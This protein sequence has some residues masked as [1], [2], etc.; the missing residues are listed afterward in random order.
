MSVSCEE[1]PASHFVSG[2]KKQRK[3]ESLLWR[4]NK[5]SIRTINLSDFYSQFNLDLF[6]KKLIKAESKL[7]VVSTKL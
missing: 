5:F 6:L 3:C 2:S 4:A 1:I 7:V